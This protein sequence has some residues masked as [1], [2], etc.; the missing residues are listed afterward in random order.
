MT[1]QEEQLRQLRLTNAYLNPGLALL[2]CFGV[3]CGF[4][5]LVFGLFGLMVQLTRPFALPAPAVSHPAHQIPKGGSEQ[6]SSYPRLVK[7]KEVR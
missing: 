3:V 2:K 7:Q 1:E 6:P 4:L 5:F